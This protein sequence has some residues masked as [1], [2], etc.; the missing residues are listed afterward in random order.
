MAL[1]WRC[2]YVHHRRCPSGAQSD[3]GAPGAAPAKDSGDSIHNRTDVWMKDNDSSNGN[4]S[5]VDPVWLSPDIKVCHS[6]SGC[7]DSQDPLV[8][9]TN[10]I[11]VTLRRPVPLETSGGEASGTVLLYFHPACD[12]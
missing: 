8:G 9:Q 5:D 3:D 4:E 6:Q 12:R 11:F 7:T 1:R 10:W 2:C